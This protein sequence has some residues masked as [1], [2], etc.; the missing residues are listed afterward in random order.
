MFLLAPVIDREPPRVGITVSRKVGNAVVRNRARRLVREAFRALPDFAPV[1]ADVIVVVR[2]PLT[3]LGLRH[4]VQEWQAVAP[5][6]R[7]KARTM[8]SSRKQPQGDQP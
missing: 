7:R 3:G 5:V 4:V 1:D 2:A 8:A 6:V